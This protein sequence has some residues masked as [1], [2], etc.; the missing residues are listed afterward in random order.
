[1][2][3][4]VYDKLAPY[5]CVGTT[6]LNSSAPFPYQKDIG[7]YADYLSKKRGH[8]L[9]DKNSPMLAMQRMWQLPRRMQKENFVGAF[10]QLPGLRKRKAEELEQDEAADPEVLQEGEINPLTNLATG[11]LPR[12]VC[13]ETQLGDASLFLQTIMLPQMIYH[14]ERI[15]ISATFVQHCKDK[16]P[17]LGSYIEK[18][19]L[20]D[21][22]ECLT[23]KSCS[24]TITYD[25]FE[26][27][28]DAVLKLLHTDAL[29]A[30]RDLQKWVA[31][32]HE[33]DLTT[34]RSAMGSNDRLKDAALSTGLEQF[35]LTKPL[36]RGQWVP[37][38]I[39]AYLDERDGP[40]TEELL[41]KDANNIQ[42]FI[43]SHKVCADVIEAILGIVYLDF[44]Y[45][46]SV[47]VAEELG[48][49][50]PKNTE[51]DEPND[52]DK[53]NKD[54]T[55]IHRE[56]KNLATEFLDYGK[57]DNESLLL[58]SLTHPSCIHEEVPCYQRLEWI[59][60][61]VL[62]LAARE[63]V[64][65]NFPEIHVSE[66]VVIETSLVCNETLAY[67]G[68][69]SGVHRHINHRDPSLPRRFE[70]YERNLEEFGRG[71][72]GT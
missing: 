28:G 6:S 71:L 45:E 65:H 43:P 44:G 30:S 48:I 25:R 60:D 46:A 56:L 55:A 15:L 14:V 41:K 37:P 66:L 40:I 5:V 69:L 63:W 72:W 23:A 8:E 38:G 51:N 26:Y 12:E 16:L 57:F 7:S 52:K 27:L 2:C 47:K 22:L 4:P 11:L 13:M 18:L 19:K 53:A 50:L 29:L 70:E 32:L 34:L 1:M 61:A 59:G 64:F 62:C 10:G 3:V 20:S 33:G 17:V 31:Y 24:M 21:V 39:E 35:I 9:K 58:E 36:G 68:Y 42:M 54:H 49:S 67:L